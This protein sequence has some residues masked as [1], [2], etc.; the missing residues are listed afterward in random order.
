[1]GEALVVITIPNRLANSSTLLV[2]V[3]NTAE[4]KE[5]TAENSYG[6]VRV[7]RKIPTLSAK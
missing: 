2:N 6:A 7:P 5:N 1:M 4:K 3:L